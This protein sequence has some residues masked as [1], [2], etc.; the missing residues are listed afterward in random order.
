MATTPVCKY[1]KFGHCKYRSCCRNRHVDVLCEDSSCNIMICEK[2]HPVICK[3]FSSYGR[4]KYNPC[5]YKHVITS[6]NS[7]GDRQEKIVDNENKI[8]ENTTEIK[9][10]KDQIA[11]L[12]KT[13]DEMRSLYSRLDNLEIAFKKA[14][15]SRHFTSYL[16]STSSTTA[17]TCS[18]GSVFVKEMDS[19]C[20]DHQ[21]RLDGDIPPNVAC[22]YHRCR[23]QG[24][25]KKWLR[26]LACFSLDDFTFLYCKCCIWF[27]N[28][29][30]LLHIA[31]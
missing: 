12:Q 6:S 5:S 29:F 26:L 24:R 19:A 17:E 14:D 30:W 21:H 13:L 22:C 28:L 27:E 15:S 11:K 8:R 3:F 20:C 23:P 31:G 4:C 9:E 16:T 25:K 18:T 7:V 2:R 1:F 10:L